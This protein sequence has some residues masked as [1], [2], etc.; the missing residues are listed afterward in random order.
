MAA[1]SAAPFSLQFP[2][3]SEAILE[4]KTQNLL[5]TGADILVSAEPSCLMNI[6]GWLKKQG[7]AMRVLHIAQVLATHNP[8]QLPESLFP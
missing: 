4:E 1:A 6:G 5:D 7:H 8:D 2:G 3:V